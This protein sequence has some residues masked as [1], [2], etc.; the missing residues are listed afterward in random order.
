MELSL[1]SGA[2]FADLIFQKCHVPAAGKA[3]YIYI[4]KTEL[5]LQSH[6]L[7]GQQRG[8]QPRKQRPY[9][10]LLRRR[11]KVF[12]PVNSHASTVT[13]PNYSMMGG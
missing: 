2:H 5:S 8:P 11:A 13:F 4:I 10:T 1:L 12:S 7:F 9:M 6:A 3:Y